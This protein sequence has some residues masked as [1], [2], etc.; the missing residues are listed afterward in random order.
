MT[1]ETRQETVVTKDGT[2]IN[3][4]I[5]GQPLTGQVVTPTTGGG[6]LM[7]GVLWLIILGLAASLILPQFGINLEGVKNT[8]RQWQMNWMLPVP[9]MQQM[10]LQP[11][12]IMVT[13]PQQWDTPVVADAESPIIPEQPIAP[14]PSAEA[15]QDSPLQPVAFKQECTL[16][17]GRVVT[18]LRGYSR[19]VADGDMAYL[20]TQVCHR[21]C[22]MQSEIAQVELLNNNRD[23]RL[24]GSWSSTGQNCTADSKELEDNKDNSG[25]Q[26]TFLSLIPLGYGYRYAYEELQKKLKG[27][28]DK[29][30]KL[31]S[32]QATVA[33][34]S[35]WDLLPESVKGLGIK[36][37]LVLL[38]VLL[39]LTNFGGMF[40]KI[41]AVVVVI[42][43][44]LFVFGT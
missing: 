40:G 20:P 43:I 22:I 39:I 8:W 32:E 24:V 29:E 44:F 30:K 19:P 31:E 14:T 36:G 27:G 28:S 5:G 6:S 4:Y 34:W 15:S 13:P 25:V 7:S 23:M 26:K 33:G 37:L 17:T 1:G 18:S 9:P 12:P 41:I 38:A 10:Q 42:G 2:S 16:S 21:N 35:L 11:A 3:I